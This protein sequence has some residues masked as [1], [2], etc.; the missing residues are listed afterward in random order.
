MNPYDRTVDE[1]LPCLGKYTI[2]CD[3]DKRKAAELSEAIDTVERLGLLLRFA[4]NKQ[5]RLQLGRM[6]A[7][8]C[9]KLEGLRIAN[10]IRTTHTESV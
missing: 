5:Q 6:Y 9:Q 1:K 3:R 2:P 10:E 7:V 8:A 4:P